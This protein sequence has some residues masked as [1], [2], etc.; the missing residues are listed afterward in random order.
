[1][2]DLIVTTT[3]QM[4]KVG[5]NIGKF[6]GNNPAIVGESMKLIYEIQ[7]GRNYRENLRSTAEVEAYHTQA[8]IQKAQEID[9]FLSKHKESLK[10]EDVSKLVDKFCNQF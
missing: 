2:K 7:K 3:K 8:Q 10:E 4:G 9:E 6:M 1:M 5:G